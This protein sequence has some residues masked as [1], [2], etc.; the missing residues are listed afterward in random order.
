MGGQSHSG[1]VLCPVLSFTNAGDILNTEAVVVLRD[2]S[3][4]RDDPCGRWPRYVNTIRSPNVRQG[5]PPRKQHMS[6]VEYGSSLCE[7]CFSPIMR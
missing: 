5:E 4:R 7:C 1:I 3:G 6:R 2:P